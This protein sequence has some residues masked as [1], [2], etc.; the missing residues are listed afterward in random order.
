MPTPLVVPRFAECKGD[1][2]VF[3]HVLYLSPH[4]ARQPLASWT[5]LLSQ[6]EPLK[7]PRD[8]PGGGEGKRG[9]TGQT[10]QDNEIHHQHG[11]KHRHIEDFKPRRCEPQ[12]NRPRT[13]MP[14]FELGQPAYEGSELL[15]LFR[16]QGALS[17]L[18]AFVL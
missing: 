8:R 4:C 12:Q 1:V 6:A 7:L 16:R 3:D 18:D 5:L 2:A 10:E 11:P 14:E 15:V 13:A 9:L 17:V